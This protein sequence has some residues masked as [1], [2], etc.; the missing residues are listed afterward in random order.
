MPKKKLIPILLTTGIGLLL[1]GCTEIDRDFFLA[2]NWTLPRA[3]LKAEFRS[4][5][6]KEGKP[7]SL[8]QENLIDK[9]YEFGDPGL[10]ANFH[11]NGKYELSTFPGPT[12]NLI[13]ADTAGTWELQGET[14]RLQGTITGKVSDFQLVQYDNS[15]ALLV[16][17]VTEE[18]RHP[19]I[20]FYQINR[21]KLTI[22][23]VGTSK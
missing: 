14:L 15:R 19:G 23:M 4:Y 7:D 18:V 16:K 8:T 11:E 1:S 21:Q 22:T 13:L 12:I 10:K 9:V 5:E 2:Q 3:V 20:Q 17:D 6:I